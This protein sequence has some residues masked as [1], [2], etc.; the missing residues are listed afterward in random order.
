[1]SLSWP[2]LIQNTAYAP[3]GFSFGILYMSLDGTNQVF[4]GL[5]I[6]WYCNEAYS[7]MVH[8]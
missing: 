4:S 2:P 6:A 1:L 8:K 3:G 7:P 5:V